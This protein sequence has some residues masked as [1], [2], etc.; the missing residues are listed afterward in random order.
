MS[1]NENTASD[2]KESNL[3][4]SES[5]VNRDSKKRRSTKECLVNVITELNQNL[6]LNTNILMEMKESLS[7]LTLYHDAKDINQKDIFSDQQSDRNSISKLQGSTTSI[8]IS[9]DILISEMKPRDLLLRE[10]CVKVEIRIVF[11]KIGEIE[12][13]KEQFQAEAFI[14]AKW[15]EPSINRGELNELIVF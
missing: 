13:I 4:V 14:E 5:F 10:E 15:K 7:N 6:K 12:T 3:R 8:D 11:L 1:D 9:K 2:N